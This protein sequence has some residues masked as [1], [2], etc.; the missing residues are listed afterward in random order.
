MTKVDMMRATMDDIVFEGRNK[1]YGGYVIRK[2][3][4]KRMSRAIIT[5]ILLFT[6]LFLLAGPLNYFKNE[7][8]ESDN[9]IIRTVLS[10]PHF[11]EKVKEKI[12]AASKL[13]VPPAKDQIKYVPPT[14]V[15]DEST[16]IEELLPG[17]DDLKGNEIS[18]ETVSGEEGGIDPSLIENQGSGTG[19]VEEEVKTEEP[20]SFVEQMPTFPGGEIALMKFIKD[21][22]KIPELAKE[23]RITGQVFVQFVVT[24]TGEIKHAKILRG[25]GG[26]CNEEAL[27]VVNIMPAW[28][29]GKH[30]GK[31]VEVRFTLPIRLELK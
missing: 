27:R 1:L 19:Y 15:R 30:N 14:V 6:V 12:P 23:T 7:S 2:E 5:G 21:N 18:T 28:N 11:E 25:I 26:G 31:L 22:F 8:E 13:V 29:P 17:F 20:L 4:N 3:Y 24:K 16:V 9:E 10:S